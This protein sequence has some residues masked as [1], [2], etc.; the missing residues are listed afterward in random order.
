MYIII[1]SL[2]FILPIL[3]KPPRYQSHTEPFNPMKYKFNVPAALL[4][5]LILGLIQV[6]FIVMRVLRILRNRR[7]AVSKPDEEKEDRRD[8]W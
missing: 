1:G 5:F 6:V 7:N 2:F 4:I 8:E 3:R